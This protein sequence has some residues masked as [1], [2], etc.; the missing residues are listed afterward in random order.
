M[1]DA[2]RGIALVA[3]I[4]FH[5]S[6]NLDVFGF[7]QLGVMSSP[8][9]IWF[10]RIIAGSFI[11]LAGLSLLLAENAGHGASS[12]VKR[13]AKIS[14]AAIAVSIATY[15][16]FPESFVYFGILHHIALASLLA[17]P[18]LRMNSVVLATIAIAV[19]AANQSFAFEFANTHWLAWIGISQE[20]PATND[21]VP[22]VPW[23]SVF[24]V[25]MILGKEI[26]S[27]D[28][29][30]RILKQIPAWTTPLIWM[31]RRSLP[32]Y[33]LH[34]PILFGM[35]YGVFMLSR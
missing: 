10:A 6:W 11:L 20:I 19:V 17:W 33:L 3:M 32:I 13:I 7:A 31:G 34:Q 8:G 27:Q 28:G 35:A 18:L 26:V 4:I 15:F 2:L 5:G 25:G 12:K 14:I 23:F 16:V 22:L 29:V 9:W 30:S 1:V 24:L 21:Y